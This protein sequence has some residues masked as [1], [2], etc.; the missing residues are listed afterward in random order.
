MRGKKS[1]LLD[2]NSRKM[3]EVRNKVTFKPAIHVLYVMVCCCQLLLSCFKHSAKLLPISH[4]NTLHASYFSF[5]F[6]LL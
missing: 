5:W 4:Y 1:E 6:L 3:L 2:V